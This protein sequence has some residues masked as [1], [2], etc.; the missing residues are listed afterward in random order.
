MSLTQNYLLTLSSL[1]KIRSFLSNELYDALM[2]AISERDDIFGARVKVIETARA[3]AALPEQ[4]DPATLQSVSVR[5]VFK[6][7]AARTLYI[8]QRPQA[9]CA[10]Q[11]LLCYELDHGSSEPR[12]SLLSLV[13]ILEQGGLLDFTFEP[14]RLHELL[15]KAA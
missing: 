4:I 15:S 9:Q 8:L 13:E 10:Q 12:I 2:V 11:P 14:T 7:P 6:A 3:I 5:F 1:R